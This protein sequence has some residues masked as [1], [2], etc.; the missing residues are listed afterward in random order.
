MSNTSPMI[1]KIT[2]S[3]DYN[4]WLKRLYIHLNEP[5]NQNSIK[6]PKFISH[7]KFENVVYSI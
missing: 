7:K 1:L 6:Y 3:V 4:Y 5:T 2:S